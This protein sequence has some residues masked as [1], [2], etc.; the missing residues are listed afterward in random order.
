MSENLHAN[1]TWAVAWIMKL[2]EQKGIWLFRFLFF[3]QVATF[4]NLKINGTEEY[5]IMSLRI[6]NF[7]HNKKSS[8]FDRKVLPVSDLACKTVKLVLFDIVQQVIDIKYYNWKI[9]TF[10]F[11]LR[12]LHLQHIHP[13]LALVGLV[14]SLVKITFICNL[15]WILLVFVCSIKLFA[16]HQ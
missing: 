11:S 16:L 1:F 12:R 2:F 3:I 15:T 9:N 7:L 5:K 4:S 6:S 14:Y 8:Q 13:S 10:L